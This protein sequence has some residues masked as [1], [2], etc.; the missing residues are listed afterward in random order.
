MRYILFLSTIIPLISWASP[1]L[2]QEDYEK[3]K[4]F[5]FT[6]NRTCDT[7]KVLSSS[8]NIGVTSNYSDGLSQQI[9]NDQT[10]PRLLC[11]ISISVE[12]NRIGKSKDHPYEKSKN[13]PINQSITKKQLVEEIIFGPPENFNLKCDDDG[14]PSVIITFRR[15]S[16]GLNR[17][18][19]FTPNSL[20]CS[21]GELDT[22]L[23]PKPQW[24]KK[25]Q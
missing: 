17:S 5:Q 3:I 19:E 22:W 23:K 13:L 11:L 25:T 6:G 12:T 10:D 14:F 8:E 1:Y 21:T 4:S 18:I 15:D 9:L 7:K 24:R 2:A 16:K 20:D